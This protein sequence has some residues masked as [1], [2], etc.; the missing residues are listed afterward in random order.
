MRINILSFIT[1]IALL[2]NFFDIW[3]KPIIYL[4]NNRLLKIFSQEAELG[5]AFVSL[6]KRSHD[7][8]QTHYEIARRCSGYRLVQIKR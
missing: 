3:K 6:A 4:K 1:L 2:T 7:I 8:G 5:L